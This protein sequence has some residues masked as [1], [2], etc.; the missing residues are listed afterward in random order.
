MSDRKRSIDG[1]AI[2]AAERIL[3]RKFCFKCARHRPTD[4]GSMWRRGWICADCTAR[5]ATLAA[6]RL[7]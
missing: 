3:G 7:S 6:R 5:Q 1:Q 4:G 2:A